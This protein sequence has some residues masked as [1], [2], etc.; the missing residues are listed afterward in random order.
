MYSF[1]AYSGNNTW[2]AINPSQRRRRRKRNILKRWMK[3]TVRISLGIQ[4]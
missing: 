3:N 1:Y 4:G 2:I